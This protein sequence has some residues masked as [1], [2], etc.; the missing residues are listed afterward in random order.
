MQRRRTDRAKL[1]RSMGPPVAVVAT[2]PRA[3]QKGPARSSMSAC[4]ACHSGPDPEWLE[5][6]TRNLIEDRL[7]AS[8]NIIPTIRSLYR[9]QGTIEDET[10][11]YLAGVDADVAGDVA[12]R[13]SD[14]TLIIA[15][16]GG[17]AFGGKI[18]R[19][20]AGHAN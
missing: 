15:V 11:A 18:D 13:A 20:A 16:G 3:A 2:N 19:L 12:V 9:W 14:T 8:G 7:A 1:L 6:H 17:I 10:E 4:L 5:E